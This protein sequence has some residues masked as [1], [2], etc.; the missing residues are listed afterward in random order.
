VQARHTGIPPKRYRPRVFSSRTPHSFSTF[1]IDGLVAGTWRYESGGM[2][3]DAFE[4]LSRHA[5]SELDDELEVALE[6]HR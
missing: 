6:L 3:V 5:R 2:L 4:P 1:L